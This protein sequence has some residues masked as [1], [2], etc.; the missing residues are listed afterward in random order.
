MFSR[1]NLPLRR[2]NCKRPSWNCRF[3][4]ST[5][6]EAKDEKD[7]AGIFFDQ[8]VQQLLTTL[9]RVD[10]QKVF[11]ARRDGTRLTVPK[12]QFMTEEELQ[13]ARAEIGAKAR[14]RIQMPP[15][16][17]PR[18]EE[19]QVLSDDP[20]L[21]SFLDSNIVFTDISVNGNNKERLIVVREPNGLLR[22]ALPNERHRMNQVYFPIRGREVH[23]PQMFY[24]PY[25]NDLLKREEF[26]FI[27]DRAC[28]QFEPD[29]PEYHRVTKEV[30]SY[31][32][33]LKKFNVLRSTRHFGPFAFHLAWEKEIDALLV[34]LL[35]IEDLEEAVALIQ[36][37]HRIHPEAES[38][39]EA[40]LNDIDLIRVYAELEST[41]RHMITRAIEVHQALRNQKE[42]V[43]EGV[44]KAHGFVDENIEQT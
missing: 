8:Y 10:N 39:K 24:N 26:E 1:I 33:R 2:F 30:Y 4:S 17:K 43:Q 32:N 37:Y 42:K 16:V 20:A 40:I 28:L 15:V 11:A 18:S 23:T 44:M 12:F 13:E 19:V 7:P 36:L 5:V 41:E 35:K 34:D 22:H 38:A 21:E 31:L 29:D 6:P 27:L 25:L 9:T 14:G 3:C